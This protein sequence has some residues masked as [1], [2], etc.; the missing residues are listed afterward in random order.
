MDKDFMD[1]ALLVFF[2]TLILALLRFAWVGYYRVYRDDFQDAACS[3]NPPLN[4]SGGG[5]II[6][7]KTPARKHSGNHLI[8]IEENVFEK[9]PESSS[10]S[11]PRDQRKEIRQE[12]G[13]IL[14]KKR[15]KKRRKSSSYFRRVARAFTEIPSPPSSST[16]ST[17]SSGSASSPTEEETEHIGDALLQASQESSQAS[18]EL[19]EIHLQTHREH[20]QPQQLPHE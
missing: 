1:G 11:T 14:L 8:I 7:V 9:T 5:N 3:A 12:R 10:V 16:Q 20:L 13:A 15:K 4:G 6:T 2:L 18:Q 17:E 19:Q